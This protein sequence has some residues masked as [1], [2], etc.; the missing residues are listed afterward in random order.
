MGVPQMVECFA[1]S[2]VE[3]FGGI[4]LGPERFQDIGF[5]W[6]RSISMFA[7]HIQVIVYTFSDVLSLSTSSGV[8]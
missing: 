3:L 6:L 1:F 8:D 4:S 7:T 2:S 5:G